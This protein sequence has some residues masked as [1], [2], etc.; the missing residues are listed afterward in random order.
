[1]TTNI[2]ST[3]KK[4]MLLACIL[5]ANAAAHSLFLISFPV[6]GRAIGLTDMQTGSIL[7][8]S[9]L[10]MIF[11]SPW[12]GK[13]IEKT[14]RIK[15]IHVGIISTAVFLLLIGIL[16]NIERSWGLSASVLFCSLIVLRSLQAAGVTGL[17]P[18]AQAYVADITDRQSRTSGM[19]MLG[20]TFGI[21]SI[22][23][24]TLAMISGQ[25]GFTIA[26]F[27]LAFLMIIIFLAVGRKLPEQR[28][29]QQANN[30]THDSIDLIAVYPYLLIT[31]CVLLAYGMLQQITGLRLQDGLGYNSSDAIKGT[32][33]LM[34]TSMALMACVQAV[35]FKSS[36]K[37][38]ARLLIIGALISVLGFYLLYVG[39][40][41]PVYLAAMAILGIGMGLML[42]A[43]LALLSLNSNE[44]NQARIAS[45]N[46][47]GKGLGFASGPL[48]G[49]TLY[50]QT[51]DLPIVL[52]MGLA[53]ITL[54]LSLISVLPKFLNVSHKT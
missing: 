46:N 31:F 42:P 29:I 10:A 52:A 40:T 15:A 3:K 50:Q 24:G 8:I 45:I 20:A 36:V 13:R 43:N 16:F 32:G 27:S 5:F 25:G 6:Y 53:I 11:L 17:M 51:S 22:I 47:I 12:W 44:N 49:A 54:I 35:I 21:G 41:F 18:A 2:I 37:Q 4:F 1:M 30:Q 26:L 14:G 19:G 23:G 28:C 38:P 9:A 34:S 48:L 7:S 33:A 39:S